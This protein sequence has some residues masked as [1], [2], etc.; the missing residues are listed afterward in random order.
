MAGFD[1]LLTFARAGRLL[2]TLFVVHQGDHL[3]SPVRNLRLI[4]LRCD[5]TGVILSRGHRGV[6]AL[7][8]NDGSYAG[9]ASL[10]TT[11][12]HPVRPGAVRPCAGAVRRRCGS[13]WTLVCRQGAPYPWA[14]L[15]DEW[16]ASRRPSPSRPARAAA[17]R[18]GPAHGSAP[19]APPRSVAPCPACATTNPP[20]ARLCAACATPLVPGALRAAPLP[21]P[22]PVAERRLV[23]VLFADLVGFTPYAAER[24][25]EEVRETLTRYFDLAGDVIGR[26]GGRSR[27][28]SA[29]P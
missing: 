25:A 9:H 2:A 18:T 5:R 24:D 14:A 19:S 11:L 20:G 7:G 26:Y 27:S 1:V 29:T 16:T 10:A 23:S 13:R 8:D 15:P 28:S 3:S 12:F 22:E 21:A 4:S 6:Y 17:R